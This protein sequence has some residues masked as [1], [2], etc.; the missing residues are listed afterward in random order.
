MNR[1]LKAVGKG[2]RKKDAMQLLMGKP[3][4]VQDVTPDDCLVVRVL[5]SPHAN[6]NIESINCD[7]ARKVPGVVGVYTWEDVPQKRFTMAGQ[8]YPEPSPY[9]R[10]ILD[11]HVRF[12]GDAVAIVAAETLE[13]AEKAL[14]LIKVT[15]EVLP[16]LL[17]FHE[18]LDNPLLVHP[19]EN[20]KALC[21][22][23]ADNRRNLCAKGEESDGDVEAVMADC[24]VSF[25]RTFHTKAVHQAMM[26]TFRT[27][28]EIDHYGSTWVISGV[29][30]ER[31]IAN[32]N[33]ADY[34]SRNYFDL[35]L[36]KCG[37]FDRLEQMGIED[38][39]TV[40]IYDFEFD[41]QR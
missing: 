34:E 1:D 40:S 25:T 19:E 35:Q 9:D 12:V 23:G 31:L 2:V 18:A 26:E 30:L 3:A 6:A 27:Y 16:A 21:D 22:V 17:D 20:W 36:R 41:Y 5:R 29:W 14:R 33:F 8:T 32:I 10:L 37:L 39:D 7:I 4:Y 24:E 13:A 11:R 15:Y 38:G 28:T